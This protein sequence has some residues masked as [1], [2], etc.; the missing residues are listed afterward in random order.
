V[1]KLSALLIFCTTLLIDIPVP[2]EYNKIVS[3]K[4]NYIFAPT[5]PWAPEVLIRCGVRNEKKSGL[6]E[7]TGRAERVMRDP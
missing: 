5:V 3:V 2:K 1:L 6:L 4:I 7:P